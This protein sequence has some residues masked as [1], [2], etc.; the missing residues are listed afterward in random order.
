MSRV[1]RGC[2][3]ELYSLNLLESC[4]CGCMHCRYAARQQALSAPNPQLPSLLVRELERK[5]RRGH[6]PAFILV[7]NSCEPFPDSKEIRRI[8][9]NCI[10]VLLERKIGVSLETRGRV[11]KEAISLFSRH[12]RLMRVRVSIPSIDSDI[13]STWEPGCVDAET[14]IYNLQQL[15]HAGIPAMLHIGPII[16]FIN[17]DEKH[18][19][20]LIQTAADLHLR[21]VSAS[22]LRL[23][24]GAG[25][26][27]K[28]MAKGVSAMILN[29]Y[30]DKSVY[31]PS[32]RQILPA[33]ERHKI[34]EDLRKVA[35]KSGLGVGICRCHDEE[36]G[37]PPC[38]LGFGTATRPVRDVGHGNLSTHPSSPQ[39]KTARPTASAR[40]RAKDRSLSL[41][42]DLPEE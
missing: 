25:K 22:V 30:M 9:L 32:P 34:Y 4:P 6:R 7:G 31:P 36:L 11:P 14:R 38:S 35:K 26:V 8:A 5:S 23:Y 17:D 2:H 39:N 41:F 33:R 15:R 19:R 18:Y 10:Q 20:E 29:S 3:G 21:R 13:L 37:S 27:L 1:R 16:P 12:R 24:P 28:S 40:V 42:P